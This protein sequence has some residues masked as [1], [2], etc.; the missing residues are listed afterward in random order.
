MKPGFPPMRERQRAPSWE[1]ARRHT[2]H[3]ENRAQQPPPIE[4]AMLTIVPS[5]SVAKLL[6]MI[7]F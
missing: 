3:H 7:E 6:L 2:C 1:N 5:T 4:D